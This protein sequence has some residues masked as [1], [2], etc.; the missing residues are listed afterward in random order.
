MFLAKTTCAKLTT[1]VE[2]ICLL[3]KLLVTPV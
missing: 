3:L 2:L 1:N